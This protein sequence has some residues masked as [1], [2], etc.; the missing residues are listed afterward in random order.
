[1]GQPENLHD[2]ASGEFVRLSLYLYL[3]PKMLGDAGTQEAS[4][5][6]FHDHY[7]VAGRRRAIELVASPDTQYDMTVPTGI[8]SRRSHIRISSFPHL[9][10]RP[11]SKPLHDHAYVSEFIQVGSCH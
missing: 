3:L 9:T 8:E 10:Q 4:L 11:M 5:R 2:D 1:M 7:E 6:T